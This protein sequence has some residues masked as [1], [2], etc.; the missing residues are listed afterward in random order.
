[1]FRIAIDSGHG[2]NTAG[3]EVPGYMGYGKIK[4]WTLND[5]ITRALMNL[6]KDYN[7]EIIRLDDPIGQK[8]IPVKDRAKKANAWGAGI[9]IS[10]HHNAGVKGGSGGGLVVIRKAGDKGFTKAMQGLL[11]DCILAETGLKGNRYEPLAEY[12]NLIL[13]NTAKMP[14]VL[15]EHGFMDSPSDMK[16]I[17]QD[18]FA[19]K[20]ARGII[21]FLEK[22]YKIS[23]KE[24]DKVDDFK[25]YIRYGEVLKKGAK[26]PKVKSLQEDLIELGYGK[27][28]EPWGADSSFGAATEAA[29]KALQEDNK[30]AVDGSVGKATQAKISELIKAREIDYKKLYEEA[31]RKLADIKKIIG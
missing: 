19:E 29:V 24:A 26:G 13:L 20:S 7:V 31:S 1:M 12:K 5:K 22:Q 11:Y 15:I 17:M 21:R 18:D 3:K 28:L 2:L 16:V 27:M 9:L 8:D 30:L 6:L 23:K 25:K 14:T 10:N 4:E